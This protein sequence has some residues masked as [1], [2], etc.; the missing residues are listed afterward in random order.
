MKPSDPMAHPSDW[1]TVTVREAI[2]IRRGV[3]WSKEQEHTSA[4]DGAIRVVGISNV[5]KELDLTTV[6]YLSGVKPRII[7]KKR[8]AFGWSLMVGSN[9]NRN[10]LGNAVIMRNDADFLFGSFLLAA[11]PKPAFPITPEFFYRW[12]SSEP[13]QAHLSASSEG[14]T[15]L[16]NL[17]HSFF[18]NLKI[19]YPEPHEQEEIVKVLDVVDA[20]L[21]AARTARDR[22]RDAKRA[23]R[24]Q[25]FANGLR[26]D[27]PKKTSVG[28]IPAAWNVREVRSVVS[29]FQYG[30]SV[31]MQT[32]GALPILRMGNIQDGD[33]LLKDLKYVT[34]P[35]RTTSPYMLSRGDVLF[36]RTNSQ[37][38]VG[39]IGVY[40]SDKPAVFA[41]YLI[42][43]KP[44][45]SQV[46]GYFLGHLLDSHDVQCRIK[47]YATP[48]VQQVNINA[49]NLG[50]VLIAVPPGA[51]GLQEQKQVAAILEQ[52]DTAIRA[53]GPKLR[54]LGELKRSLMHDLLTGH[55][56]LNGRLTDVGAI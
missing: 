52:A 51:D 10:R 53:Y 3:S 11:R 8:V 41:S 42:R 13:I 38:L 4:R 5:Q 46:D 44:D 28:W 23:L 54:A 33:V 29:E 18:R 45:A 24:Q 47:R 17:S 22:A 6:L 21:S 25:L 30:L 49:T 7:D 9:G 40:R 15:G 50:K 34:L 27:E 56:R 31:S 16:N 43:L 55:V 26:G 1:R 2:E 20:A 48:G 12:L 37:E 36:N 19:A 39:K 32:A 14:T 35:E